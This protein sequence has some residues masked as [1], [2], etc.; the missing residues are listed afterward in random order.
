VT[1]KAGI[2]PTKNQRLTA[3]SGAINKKLLAH[4]TGNSCKS[5]A[6]NGKPRSRHIAPKTAR[7][8]KVSHTSDRSEYQLNGI[9][10][11]GCN[12]TEAPHIHGGV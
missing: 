4:K 12:G 7:F 11:E 8:Y 1:H 10:S 2:P 5:R 9:F 3:E 6:Y